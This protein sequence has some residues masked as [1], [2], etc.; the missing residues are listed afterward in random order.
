MSKAKKELPIEA[1]EKKKRSR[2]RRI[3]ELISNF[4]MNNSRMFLLAL[5]VHIAPY[6][7]PVWRPVSLPIPKILT[8][9]VTCIL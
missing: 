6:P 1:P 7:R 3:R 9:W 8:D 5:A 4:P 2:T